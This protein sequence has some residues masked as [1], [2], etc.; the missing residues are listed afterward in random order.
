MKP[1]LAACSCPVLLGWV[2]GMLVPIPRE[3]NTHEADCP[4]RGIAA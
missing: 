4:R 2:G 1:P 3:W